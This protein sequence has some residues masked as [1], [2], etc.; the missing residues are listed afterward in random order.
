MP[1]F[2]V[3]VF[4][5]DSPHHGK[6]IAYDPNGSLQDLYAT[7]TRKLNMTRVAILYNESGA[8][9]DDISLIRDDDVLYAEAGNVEQ[10][11]FTVIGEHSDFETEEPKLISFSTS[12][13]CEYCLKVRPGSEIGIK[14]INNNIMLILC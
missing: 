3:S 8:E 14:K 4:K 2:R 9:V 12:S 1:R 13:R 5:E 11:T 6:V 7:I 10:V